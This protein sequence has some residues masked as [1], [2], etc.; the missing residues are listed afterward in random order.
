MHFCLNRATGGNPIEPKGTRDD[1]AGMK[2]TIYATIAAVGL[3]GT[4]SQINRAFLAKVADMVQE[5]AKKISR[6]LDNRSTPKP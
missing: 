5:A 4:T 3:S 6:G 2:K 1:F